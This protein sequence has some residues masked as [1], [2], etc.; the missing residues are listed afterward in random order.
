MKKI[1]GIML[2]LALMCACLVSFAACGGDGDDDA[3]RNGGKGGIGDKSVAEIVPGS[4]T[5]V[6]EG[7]T[8]VQNGGVFFFAPSSW[9]VSNMG[10]VV[11]AIDSVTGSV[12]TVTKEAC[13]DDYVHEAM[14]LATFNEVVAEPMR[15]NGYTVTN[16]RALGSEYFAMDIE[17]NVKMTQVVRLDYDRESNC[18]YALMSTVIDNAVQNIFFG[19]FGIA[20]E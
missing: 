8:K 1:I 5:E 16:V 14:T 15:A 19:S 2:I 3:D 13:A 4:I 12:I 18:T 10:N 9:Q 11:I 20:K 6:P 7:Y 17:T